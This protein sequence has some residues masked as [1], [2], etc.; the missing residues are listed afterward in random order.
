VPGALCLDTTA[1]IHFEAAGALPI[2]ELM[3]TQDG[4][5]SVP[6]SV[7][8]EWHGH[9]EDP[10]GHV[11][12][13]PWL[14]VVRAD[15]AADLR[16]VADLS[17][18]YPTP[19]DKNQGEMDVVAISKRLG[20]VALMEDGVGCKQADDLGVPHLAVV[21][22]LASCVA[23]G[24]IEHKVAWRTHVAVEETRG[25]FHSILIANRDGRRG[26]AAAVFA[27]RQLKQSEGHPPLID[28]IDRPGRPGPDGMLL[29]A[30]RAAMNAAIS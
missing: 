10:A 9:S 14:T 19:P 4:S 25:Q 15:E 27:F 23:Y 26:F 7:V 16:I 2:L 21:T 24:L 1:L 22:L 5:A 18:R 20:Y 6:V 17:R 8:G 29:A 13:H 12:G 11:T 28:F 3:C 30:A